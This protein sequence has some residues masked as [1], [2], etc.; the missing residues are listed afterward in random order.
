MNIIVCLDDGNGMLFNKRR[1]SKDKKVIE[2]IEAMTDIL[3]VHSFSKTLFA[4]SKVSVK[5]DDH[6]LELAKEGEW[7]F[8]ENQNVTPYESKIEQLFIYRWNRRYP[9]DFKLDIQ[10]NR[11]TLAEQKEFVGFSHENITREQYIRG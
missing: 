2:D 6:F 7:C 8:V 5:I 1:Q 10:L 4:E 9:S 3:W 11:W